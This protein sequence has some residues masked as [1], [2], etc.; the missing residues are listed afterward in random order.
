MKKALLAG[1]ALTG[2]TGTAGAADPS[3]CARL[4]DEAR[5]ASPATWAKAD[6]LADWVKP[7]QASKASPTVTA[8]GNDA[9]WRELLS[10]PESR[11]MRV[12]QLT[13]T[14]VY[15]VADFAGTA[16]CQSLV[17]VEAKPGQPGRQIKP[18]AGTERM[19][20]CTTQWASFAQVLGQPAFVVGGAPSMVSPD[21][22]YRIATWNGRGWGQAC[23]IAIQRRTAMTAGQRFCAPG[24]PVCDA[25]QPVAQRLAQA[26]ET[27]RAAGK[28]LDALAFNGGYRPGEAV[29][30]SLGLPPGDVST[31]GSEGNP[32]FALF[33]AEETRL[34][35]MLT[36]LSNANA[37]RLPVL[38]G[39]RWWLAVVGRAGVGWREGDAVLVALFA[40][41]GRQQDA[42]ASYQFLIRP[43]GLSKATVTDGAR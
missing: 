25:G 20:L 12:Q 24:S 22:N 34:D 16:N 30:V 9:R 37:R 3:L 36:V 7:V 19:D 10:A 42:T 15:M 6:P 26:Y 21:L 33:G 35:P 17:L 28:P 18:P 38:V 27:S 32:Q 13:G 4:A 41:P 5:G 40:P 2:W 29:A 11:P 31:A 23:R 43:S 8:L 39:E 14:S 1:L